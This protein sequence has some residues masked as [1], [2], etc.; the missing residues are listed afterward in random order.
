MR[1]ALGMFVLILV[2][3]AL[4][5]VPSAVAICRHAPMWLAAAI[6][7]VCVAAPFLWHVLRERKAR[8]AKGSLKGWDRLVL[9][10]VVIA[11]LVGFG[12]WAVAKPSLWTAL[13]HHWDWMIPRSNTL[14]ADSRLLQQVPGDA[15]S[16]LWIRAGE[17]PVLTERLA[18]LG[19]MSADDAAEAVAA[20]RGDD[21]VILAVTGS[22]DVIDGIQRLVDMANG[23]E[24]HAIV[25]HE[26]DG[27]TVWSTPRWEN[28]SDHATG[29]V[30]MLERAPA[31]AAIVFATRPQPSTA[32]RA[33]HASDE[34]T[35]AVGWVRADDERLDATVEIDL[36]SEAS[37]RALVTEVEVA[38]NSS[39]EA[40]CF[41][42]T[43][44]ATHD[45]SHVA[46]HFEMGI[47]DVPG[48]YAC[49]AT[50]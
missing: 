45:G 44:T 23:F 47:D 25:S 26:R 3:L 5:D 33:K 35:S 42:G 39:A 2:W 21:D 41:D 34:V 6:G 43:W 50:K 20:V 48:M 22:S 16:V 19:G 31:D 40:R 1:R 18:A 15:E 7:G 37:A 36:P 9:R 24:K 4:F 8:E 12:S 30:A 27:A 14:T 38:A 28:A 17:S 29:L 49:L 32:K 10:T 13:K 11:L 46:L